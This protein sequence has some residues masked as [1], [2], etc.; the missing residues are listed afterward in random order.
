MRTRGYCHAVRY[1]ANQLGIGIRRRAREPPTPIDC[2]DPR[3]VDD[4]RRRRQIEH[5]SKAANLFPRLGRAVRRRA[6]RLRSLKGKLV[7]DLSSCRRNGKYG[8]RNGD[9]NRF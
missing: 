6:V 1:D 5:S 7:V 3:L 8:G 9:K 4:D 2:V